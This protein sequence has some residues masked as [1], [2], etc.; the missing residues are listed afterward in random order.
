MIVTSDGDDVGETGQFNLCGRDSYFRLGNK[1]D[2][3]DNVRV[4]GVCFWC[5]G[6]KEHR[7][8]KIVDQKRSTTRYWEFNCR[9]NCQFDTLL[10]FFFVN[11][12]G[13][14]LLNIF[15]RRLAKDSVSAE[16]GKV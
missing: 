3:I 8:G 4:S 10:T 12:R 15:G 6:E 7:Q 16:K 11:A 5:L 13:E 2:A 9:F 1:R 14:L